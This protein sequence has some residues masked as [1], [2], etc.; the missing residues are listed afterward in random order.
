MIPWMMGTHLLLMLCFV[1]PASHQQQ[2]HMFESSIELTTF[3]TVFQPRNPIEWLGISTNVH[4]MVECAMQCN[5]NR[6]CRTFDYDQ[7]SLV[8]RLFEGEF[9]TGTVLNNSTLSSSRV[10]SIVYDTT[11][12]LQSYS[13]YNQNCDKCGNGINRYLQC[14]NNSC[15]CPPNTYW[16]GQMCLNQLYNRSICNYPLDCRQDLNLTCSN[17]TKTCISLGEE[18]TDSLFGT[19]TCVA[20]CWSDASLDSTSPTPSRQSIPI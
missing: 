5:Q 10:G 8:C 20:A 17:R 1:I 6:Q 15:Q 18:G 14:I 3:G 11:D 7:S 12:T 4:S 16:N 19:Y 13:A 9:S 2:P